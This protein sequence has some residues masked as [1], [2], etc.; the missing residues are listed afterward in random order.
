MIENLTD[1]NVG[2]IEYISKQDVK[3][4]LQEKVFHNLTDEFYGVMQVLDELEPADVA[5][6]VRCK[7]CMHNND[8]DIQYSAQAGENFFCGFGETEKDV[9]GDVYE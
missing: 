9:R 3:N 2:N 8:C 7:G 5:P 1:T 4:A 6:V